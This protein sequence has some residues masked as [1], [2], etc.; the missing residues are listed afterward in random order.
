MIKLGLLGYPLSHSLSPLMHK[1]ALAKLDIE[2]E[3][4]L[5]ETPPER[6]FEIVKELKKGGYKGV[7]V[8]I[9]LKVWIIPLLDNVDDFS[10]QVGAVNTVL[11]T[12]DKQLYGYNTDVFGFI[13][14]IPQKSRIH[15]KGKKAA[16]FGTG[17]AARAVIIGL[18]NIGISE[19]TFFT[20]NLE[21]SSDFEK[22]IKTKLPHIKINFIENNYFP[23]L[24]DISI[25]IN[26]TPL[27]MSGHHRDQTP[28]AKSSIDTLPIDAIVYDLVY[29]PKETVFLEYARKRGLITINGVEMLVLQGAKAFEIWTGKPAPIDTMRKAVLENL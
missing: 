3:Y 27:G 23:D 26:C 5:I 12:D 7:N 18:D 20:R 28:A 15:L 11:V 16:I 1:A 6:L 2:G 21:N 4:K 9:P 14:S 19:I 13:N 25:A 10:N 29:K 17:G 22:L 24:K 8:T